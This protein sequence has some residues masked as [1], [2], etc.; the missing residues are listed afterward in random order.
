MRL[1]R[2]RGCGD[3]LMFDQVR[4]SLGL[5]H[6]RF[7]TEATIAVSD[8]VGTVGRKADFDGCFH[9]R[10]KTLAHRIDQ[11]SQN[12]TALDEP[13]DVYRVDRAYFVLDGH[14]RVSIAKAQGREFLDARISHAPTPYRFDPDVDP[15]AIERTA[16]EQRFRTE[17]GLL[18]A[19]PGARFVASRLE[20]YPQLRE[21]ITS[22]A[23][24]LGER[25]GR[26]L[27]LEEAS[28]L[29]YESVYRP[30]I[31]AA[32]EMQLDRLIGCLTESDLFLSIHR[33]SRELWGREAQPA[34]DEAERLVSQIM[35]HGTEN[36][37]VI[38]RVLARARNRP[39]PAVLPEQAVTNAS[40][41]PPAHAASAASMSSLPCS[42][43]GLV[44]SPSLQSG[45]RR[46]M[47]LAGRP[48]PGRV[49]STTCRRSATTS[50]RLLPSSRTYQMS[51]RSWTSAR[52]TAR[53]P[54]RCFLAAS[55]IDGLG[56][57]ANAWNHG[58]EI[59]LL[60]VNF[61]GQFQ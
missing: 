10:E 34:V 51:G 28:A 17:S 8:I 50:S 27:P 6:P 7:E 11:V 58:C 43:S 5:G 61:S 13:I 14:K 22:Y 19:V 32:E 59:V 30:T 38:E 18:Q 31:A 55:V 41:D 4:R 45:A 56:S 21:S 40:R 47:G 52:K 49:E 1:G 42:D 48:G 24:D 44:N 46:D 33:Q 54:S 12:E 37:S 57:C 53:R 25:L 3:L 36:Q 35:E 29:W 23:H 2:A 15:V 60:R 39:P 9:P 26:Q 20:G 16:T